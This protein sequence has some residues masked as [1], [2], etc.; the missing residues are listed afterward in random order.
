MKKNKKVKITDK[1]NKKSS[2]NLKISTKIFLGFMLMLIMLIFISLF[3]L[4][5]IRSIKNNMT[6][7]VEDNF[8]ASNYLYEIKNNVL[9]INSEMLLISN[10]DNKHQ[11]IQIED[12]IKNN[13]KQ[14][15]NS[16]NEYDKVNLTDKE[17]SEVTNLKS[18][19]DRYMLKRDEVAENVKKYDYKSANKTFTQSTIIREDMES[20]L[21]SMLSEKEKF[22]YSNYEK[23]IDSYDNSIK[24]SFINIGVAIIISIIIAFIIIKGISKQIAQINEVSNELKEGNLSYE[25]K[26]Y[27]EDEIGHA[28]NSLIRAKNQIRVVIKDINKNSSEIES[29][30]KKLAKISDTVNQRVVIIRESANQISI[31][32]EQLS[33]TTEEI[34]A[35]TSEITLTS[36]NLYKKARESDK[37]SKEIKE[38]AIRIKANGL[39]SVEIA[40]EIYKDK[41]E[42]INQAI[43]KGEVV[44]D[45]KVISEAIASIANQT[46]LLALNASIE[47]AR[48]GEHGRGFAVVAEEIKKLAEE[49]LGNVGSIQKIIIE[50]QDAFKNLSLNSNEVLDFI[51]EKVYPDYKLLIDTAESYEKDSYVISDMV[52]E[53]SGATKFMLENLNQVAY[54][55]ENISATA[56]ESSAG[57]QEIANSIWELSE[58]VQELSLTSTSQD[59]LADRMNKLINKFIV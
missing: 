43:K 28:I 23:S 7:V 29:S 25:I 27:K 54:A 10:E 5:N 30:S 26:D 21:D 20:K 2:R 16:I 41:H 24:V 45:I 55:I 51:E 8:K 46:N 47:A 34:N 57:A 50:V 15:E 11:I 22:A 1:K 12:R 13:I 35:S 3:G 53:I 4:K 18:L 38:K 6:I 56:E 40:K 33:S 39:E 49:S 59:K 9:K 42:K 31:G 36:E 17:K 48:A 32:A 19:I 44:K 58:D 14:I 52:A 37:T